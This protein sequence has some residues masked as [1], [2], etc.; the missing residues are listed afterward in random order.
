MEPCIFFSMTLLPIWRRI[1]R[2][3]TQGHSS[4]TTYENSRKIET[5]RIQPLKEVKKKHNKR[6]ASLENSITKK[7]STGLSFYYD[8][9]VS[10]DFLKIQFCMMQISSGS[11]LRISSG[12]ILTL[13]SML[14][15]F[16]QFCQF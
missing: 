13:K 5:Y 1:Q 2:P 7:M 15:L 3:T 8:G 16:C 11:N 6:N 4:H 10:Y 9:F 12:S 14:T